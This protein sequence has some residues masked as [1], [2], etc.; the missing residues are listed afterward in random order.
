MVL[1][2]IIWFLYDLIWFYMIS[3]GFCM[4]STMILL[5]SIMIIIIIIVIIVIIRLVFWEKGPKVLEGCPK[6]SL[7]ELAEF[8]E[9]TLDFSSR[10][11]GCN[12]GAEP[13]I[14]TRQGP[15]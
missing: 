1:L 9:L 7:Q 14:H 11:G 13:T 15:G 3:Y 2:E 4:I 12:C 5:S 10:I 6:I 8:A